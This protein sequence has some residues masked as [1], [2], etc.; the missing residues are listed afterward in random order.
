MEKKDNLDAS[1]GIL[2]SILLS[3]PIWILICSLYNIF[4]VLFGGQ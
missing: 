1:K 3:I 4:S 2:V